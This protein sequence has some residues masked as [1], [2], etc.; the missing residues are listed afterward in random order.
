MGRLP[1]LLACWKTSVV[2]VALAAIGCSGTAA[3]G[4]GPTPDIEATVEARVQA[5]IA[6][7]PPATIQPTSTPSPTP[8]LRPTVTSTPLPTPTPQPMLAEREV[9]SALTNYL[10]KEVD[11]IRIEEK[12]QD[13]AFVV[14]NATF[15]M[16]Y[17]GEGE[18]IAIGIGM[19]RT[20]QGDFEWSTG[21]WKLEEGTLRITPL[22]SEAATLLQFLDSWKNARPTPIPWPTAT[23]FPADFALRLAALEQLTNKERELRLTSWTPEE[24]QMAMDLLG[25]AEAF[26]EFLYKAELTEAQVVDIVRR[27]LALLPYSFGKSY[28][29][30]FDEGYVPVPSFK[31]QV[32][33]VEVRKGSLLLA[34]IVTVSDETGQVLDYACPR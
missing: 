30:L 10:L 1:G 8:A 31:L 19:D 16:S 26:L 3:G 17:V 22:T 12:R 33:T 34:A 2:L 7:V 5:A 20:V 24:R 13:L 14:G 15:T 21:R 23:P 25:G 18:W 6:A 9:K 28:Q 32:W 4:G 29:D 27:C 11:S